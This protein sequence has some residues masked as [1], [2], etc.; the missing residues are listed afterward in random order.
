MTFRYPLVIDQTRVFGIARSFLLPWVFRQSI[1][2][3]CFIV[4]G[5]AG[6]NFSGNV[7]AQRLLFPAPLCLW[8][9]PVQIIGRLLVR[10]IRKES[11]Y[12]N[13]CINPNDYLFLL[14]SAIGEG[15]RVRSS[16]K[17]SGYKNCCINPTITFSCSPLPL[18]R[19]WG[20][21]SNK[22][23]Y[24]EAKSE[25]NIY[26]RYKCCVLSTIKLYLWII[27]INNV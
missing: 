20:V 18:E 26:Y 8:R 25:P 11:G 24:S 1:Y 4:H 16:R 15:L 27:I 7:S 14:P 2:K 12:K 3:H 22:S 19:G 10:S 6:L 5:L 23:T 17:E 9:E 21:R 13:C